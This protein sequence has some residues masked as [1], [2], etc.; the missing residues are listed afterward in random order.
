[1]GTGPGGSEAEGVLPAAPARTGPATLVPARALT[2]RMRILHV[3]PYYH[4]SVGGLQLHVKAI[5][6]HLAARGHDV[7]VFT[8]SLS[9]SASHDVDHQLSPIERIGGVTVRRFR[10]FPAIPT[11]FL[12]VPG[13]YRSM[14]AILGRD[15]YRMLHDGPWLPQAVVAALRLSPDVILVAS[16]E[17]EALSLQFSRL[18]S[19]TSIRLVALPLLHLEHEWSRSP[20]VARYLSRFDA[21]MA[22]TEHEKAFIDAT[23]VPRPECRAVGVG[24]DPEPFEHR[25][26]RAIR[27]RYGLGDDTV[28]GYVARLQPEKG[29]IRLIEAMRLVWQKEPSTRLLLAGHRFKAGS[30]SD[31]TLQTTLDSL[32]PSHRAR[33]TVV[34]GFPE[35]DK[36]SIFDACDVFALPSIAE[37]FGIVYLE[38][39]LC[40]KPVIG[41]RIGAVQ[42]VVEDGQD[43]FLVDPHGTG[44]LSA[45]ILRLIG[46]PALCRRFGRRGREKT[47]ARF[48]WSK[49]TDS[50]EA[51]YAEALADPRRRPRR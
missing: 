8:S 46:D 2:R 45:A 7:T 49:V 21:V 31:Q 32:S 20:L 35:G 5:S 30:I 28:V 22:N 13:G 16:A 11:S 19:L 3:S 6:E 40:E 24:V 26:G 38:A 12:T 1:M 23:C 37:S 27:E 25:N 10:P 18:Q 44:E 17:H 47:L 34:E 36:A 43:G 41:A 4:P 51:V 33:V 14:R 29:V 48:T 9:G 39:W 50:V 15:Y 42:C